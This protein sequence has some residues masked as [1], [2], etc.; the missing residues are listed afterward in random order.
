MTV[1][2]TMRVAVVVLLVGA[3]A[4]FAGTVVNPFGGN[5]NTTLG[6]TSRGTVAFTAISTSSGIAALQAIGGHPCGAPTTYYHGD[7]TE[8]PSSSDTQMGTMT[9]C[10][11]AAGHLVG[12]WQGGGTAGDIEI[13]L[14]SARDGFDGFLSSDLFGAVFT[15]AGT[16]VAHFAGDGCCSTGRVRSGGLNPPGT[17]CPG[18]S[19]NLALRVTGGLQVECATRRVVTADEKAQASED[20]RAEVSIAAE[21]CGVAAAE[22]SRNPEYAA[23]Y[24]EGCPRIVDVI[25]E[26]LAIKHDPP[27]RS[28]RSPTLPPTVRVARYAAK[29]CPVG[30]NKRR[31]AALNAALLNYVYVLRPTAGVAGDVALG[32][33][34]V[35]GAVQDNSPPYAFS[36]EAFGKVNMGALAIDLAAMRAYGR[37]FARVL[38]ADHLNIKLTA[39]QAKKA[40]STLLSSMISNQLLDELVAGGLARHRAGARKLLMR[41]LTAISGAVSVSALGAALPSSAFASQYKSI[42]LSGLASIVNSLTGTG[43]LSSATAQALVSDL[44]SAQNACR[45]RRHRIAAI[46]R[47]VAHARAH[48]SASEAGFLRFGAQPFTASSVP[49]GSCQ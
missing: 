13:A 43:D 27:D 49:A 48:A 17:F 20:L 8:H 36:Q 47:F 38:R 3:S 1:G 39:R 42:T 30:L 2:R 24:V 25:G 45:N 12:R 26:T 16:F 41:R 14:N 21:M 18:R 32:A 15:Y 6:G 40:E 46:R 37:A 29:G 23:L 34:R 10:T 35:A 9:A 7:F 11:V 44:A 22:F 5:W 4:A 31:C 28:F 19:T 33:N